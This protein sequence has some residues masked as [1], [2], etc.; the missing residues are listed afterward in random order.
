LASCNSL[1]AR[2]LAK[3]KAETCGPSDQ[4][5]LETFGYSV[6]A[7]P[8]GK[9]ECVVSVFGTSGTLS[10]GVFSTVDG[11]ELTFSTIE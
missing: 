8:V 11:V 10:I 5:G 1:L 4:A 2:I 9:T 6:A 7:V 3:D